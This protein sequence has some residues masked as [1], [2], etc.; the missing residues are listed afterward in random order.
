[1]SAGES[2][3]DQ[4]EILVVEDS[5]TRAARLAHLLEKNGFAVAVAADG[6]EALARLE[7]RVPAL[8]ISDVVMPELDGYGLCKAIRSD[9]RTRDVLV[10]LVTTLSDTIDVIR[11]LECGA[12]NF[13]RKPYDEAYLLSRIHYLLM[14]FDLRQNQKMKMGVEIVLG[15]QK[16]FITAERQ[17][18]LDLLIS[19]YEQAVQINGELASKARQLAQSTE[20]LNGLY[21]IAEGLNRAASEREVAEITLERALQLPG[22]RAGWISLREGKSGFRVV[23]ARNLPP[24]LVAP[25]ALDGDCLCRRRLLSGE[26]DSVTNILECERLRRAPAEAGDLR[27]HATVPLWLGNETLGVM[28]LA[29]PRD[30][31][32]DDEALRVLYG[33]GNQVAVALERARLREHLEQLVEE[34][35]AELTAEI[36]ERGRI[37]KDQARLVAILE[38]TPDLVGTGSVDG[39]ALYC[40]QAGRLMLGLEPAEDIS[41]KR[42]L[43]FFAGPT[44]KLLVE[45][46]IPHAVE[47]G[48][49]SG[50]TALRALDG[51]EIPVSQV[52]LAHKGESGAVEYLSTIARDLSEKI[53]RD[54][55][56][57]LAQR[58]ESIG[59]LAGGIAHDL[60]N[61]LAPVLMGAE[62]LRAE[63]GTEHAEILDLLETGARRSADMVRQ[64]LTFS[65]GMERELGLVR[66]S[67]LLAEIATI[68]RNTFPKSI[69]VS[70]RPPQ[71]QRNVIGDRTQLHQVLLN[72]CINARDAMPEGGELELAAEIVEVDA[73][74]LER[75]RVDPRGGHFRIR[76]RDT[77]HGI[78]PEIL[79]RVFEPFFSTKP[80]ELGTGL[81]LSTSLGIVKSHG[82]FIHLDSHVGEDTTVD[83]F[84]PVAG[85]SAE[86]RV[87]GESAPEVHGQ[88]ELV[89]V[90][91][92]EPA[93]RDLIRVMLE[94]SGWR[95]VVASGGEEARSVAAEQ[96]AGLAWVLCDLQMPQIGGLDVMRSLRPLCPRARFVAMSGYNDSEQVEALR[97]IGVASFL[98]KPFDRR[99]LL[100]AM[101]RAAT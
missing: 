62:L 2:E 59:T 83:V 69:Q 31:L 51:R 5:P 30:G 39:Y 92:D 96:G 48:S 100:A 58:L 68:L 73:A 10:M 63:I 27:Y 9:P 4:V 49:W 64:L 95:V 88:G 7:R 67:E 13:L 87:R 75:A 101:G 3:R 18:I 45:V 26:L 78:A 99:A 32:F 84:L 76:V 6:R 55:R 37:E 89:L 56:T 29:G 57:A 74:A 93:L 44:A 36:A 19:T 47:H 1:M 41:T 98:A 15:G 90:V 60:N 25:G 21:R 12:D 20:V 28:N 23:A 61:S 50:E 42:Y 54:R 11:G 80:P 17:Q 91:D 14:N 70:L 85:S 34:R 97:A 72:L 33:V 53:A 22:V 81:G 38:A 8:V 94:R 77:G 66:P 46:G 79:D 40:N 43:D 35:T 82:G 52:V 65:K 71:R 86:I 16:H 24:A